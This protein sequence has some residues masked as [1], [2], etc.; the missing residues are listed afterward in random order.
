MEQLNLTD[1]VTQDRIYLSY[2]RPTL[3]VF[4]TLNDLLV[5]RE[6]NKDIQNSLLEAICIHI[7]NEPKKISLWKSKE[8]GCMQI[9]NGGSDIKIWKNYKIQE[10]PHF[11]L[12]NNNEIIFNISFSAITKPVIRSILQTFPQFKKQETK[13]GTSIMF[14]IPEDNEANIIVDEKISSL[15]KIS[16]ESH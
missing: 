2:S 10:L 5:L 6:I 9:Y 14:S 3:I 8:I 1:L 13:N 12:F 4:A 7:G 15:E 16:N 11:L